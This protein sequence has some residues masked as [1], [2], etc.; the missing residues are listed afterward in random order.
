[1]GQ[2]V[3]REVSFEEYRA[4]RMRDSELSPE[5]VL[6]KLFEGKGIQILGDKPAPPADLLTEVDSSRFVIR[7]QQ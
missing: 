2:V 3:I 6:M 5:Q 4:A 1:M 7:Q